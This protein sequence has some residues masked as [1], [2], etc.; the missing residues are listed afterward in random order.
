MQLPLGSHTLLI[1]FNAASNFH[2]FQMDGKDLPNR[3]FVGKRHPGLSAKSSSTLAQQVHFCHISLI[4][5][6]SVSLCP[7][8]TR[9]ETPAG[10]LNALYIHEDDLCFTSASI[11]I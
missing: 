9:S 1:L 6:S 3:I 7:Q 2:Q 4:L 5:R 10:K 11:Y 8:M